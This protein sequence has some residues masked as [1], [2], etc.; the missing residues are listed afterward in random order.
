MMCICRYTSLGM[1]VDVR[2]QFCGVNSFFFI[3][4]FLETEFRS[5]CLCGLFNWSLHNFLT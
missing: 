2:E 4:E 3:Y 5:S 1:A